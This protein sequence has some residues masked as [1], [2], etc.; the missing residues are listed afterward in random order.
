MVRNPSGQIWPMPGG[1]LG[2]KNLSRDILVPNAS[3]GW[4][5]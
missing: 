1:G 4:F 3:A 2:E 5:S